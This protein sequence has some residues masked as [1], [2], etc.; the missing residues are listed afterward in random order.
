M[1]FSIFRTASLAIAVAIF[2]LDKTNDPHKRS[3][4]EKF[5]VKRHH[6]QDNKKIYLTFNDNWDLLSENGKEMIYTRQIL[7]ENGICGSFF[8]STNNVPALRPHGNYSY[9]ST[10]IQSIK[11]QKHN[12]GLQMPSAANNHSLTVENVA[13]LLKKSSDIVYG[14][15]E[16]T[17]KFLMLPEVDGTTLQKFES[18]ASSLGMIIVKPNFDFKG[19]KDFN[20]IVEF[21]KALG[22]KSGGIISNANAAIQYFSVEGQNNDDFLIYFQKLIKKAIGFLEILKVEFGCVPEYLLHSHE[23]QISCASKQGWFN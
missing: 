20:N 23:N 10:Y 2:F 14:Y 15:I 19:K 11:D 21:L 13:D 12:I 16:I 5:I 4:E 18:A 22:A 7:K 8:L 6:T 1:S 17:P 3:L 9:F